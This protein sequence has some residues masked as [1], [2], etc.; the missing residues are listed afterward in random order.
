MRCV[1]ILGAGSWGTALA[2]LLPNVERVRLWARDAG[3]ADTIEAARANE[4]YLPGVNLRP[5]VAVT[6]DLAEALEGADCVVFAV[7]SG[8]MGEVACAAAPLLPVGALLVNAAKGL[9]EETG[10]RMSE[11]IRSAAVGAGASP[12]IAGR[13]AALSGP[14]LAVEVA[15]GVPTASVA[16]AANAETARACQALW[17]SPVFRVYTSA[18][19]VGVELAGAMKNVI[20]IGA[21]VCDG[22]GYGD[23]SRAAMMTRGLAEITRLGVALG[24]QPT[25]FLGLAG[26]GDL[27]A[28]GGSRLSR[29]F[30]VGVGLGMGRPL[31][32]VVGE[33]GQVAEGVPTTR[34]ICRL[35]E[36][37][38]M[39]VPI[40]RALH[41]VLFEGRSVQ[42]AIAELML[43]PP[44]DE[45]GY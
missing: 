23:N 34:A 6:E 43:R 3:L 32:E 31:G 18:D 29:N 7:P 8:A 44:R 9:E 38:G 11:V 27:I 15:R 17:M 10:R 13:I 16:A 42:Q 5:N 20:A 14:N 33:L 1:T 35:A 36:R 45:A 37:A 21:G 40:A 4:R 24:A 26:V 39:D 12:E 28:T 2:T 19:P 41:R 30:R 22:L 25:T